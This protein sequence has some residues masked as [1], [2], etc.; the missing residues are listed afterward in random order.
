VGE[1]GGGLKAMSVA[2]DLEHAGSAYSHATDRLIDLVVDWA[3]E[4][5][6]LEDASTLARIARTK[7]HVCMKELVARRALY[8]GVMHPGM[9]SAH[10]PVCKLFVSETYQA[11]MADLID[12]MAPDSLFH[13][14][15]AAGQIE[16]CHRHGQIATTYGGTSEVHRSTI[17]EVGLGLPR[18]R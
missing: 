17:A 7:A 2:L 4:A 15:D 10:G 3:R 6:R 8:H 14:K 9:R 11:D 18:S 12:L 1:V 16:L 5:G 13:G